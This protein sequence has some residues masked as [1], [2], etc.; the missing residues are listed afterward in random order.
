MDAVELSL[1]AL[2]YYEVV[3]TPNRRS[4]VI[5]F[6]DVSSFLI[7][8]LLTGLIEIHLGRGRYGYLL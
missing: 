7:G 8:I 2:M 3:L 1:L 5:W 6:T 4:E